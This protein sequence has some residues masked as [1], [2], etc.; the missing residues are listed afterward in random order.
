MLSIHAQIRYVGYLQKEEREAAIVALMSY[1]QGF[2]VSMTNQFSESFSTDTLTISTQ[3]FGRMP[4]GGQTEPSDFTLYLND[5]YDITLRRI[6]I[7]ENDIAAVDPISIYL[8]GESTT[9]PLELY[10]SG[11]AAIA[12][13]GIY[14]SD[15]GVVSDNFTV[16]LPSAIVYDSDTITAQLRNYV[17]ASKNWDI[18][19]F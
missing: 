2:E 1:T 7:T 10:L 16:H 5:T 9:A 12:P 4:G 11:E 19:T 18:V 14:L 3:S 13:V 15:E 6:F 8:S 17:E